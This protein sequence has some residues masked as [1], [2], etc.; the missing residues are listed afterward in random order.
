MD[1]TIKPNVTIISPKGTE[2]SSRIGES[3]KKAAKS[4]LLPGNFVTGLPFL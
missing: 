3:E 2:L 4:Y 1:F